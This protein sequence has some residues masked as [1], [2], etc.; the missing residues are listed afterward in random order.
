MVINSNR[1]KISIEHA[2][3]WLTKS[4]IQ[5]STGSRSGSVNAW[6]DIKKKKYSFIYSEINGYFITMMIFLYK[7]TKNKK[8]ID[9]ALMSAK[10][11]SKYALHKNGGFKCLF[12]IDKSSPH[13]FKQNQ[14]YSFDNGVILNGFAS[15]YKI[16]KKKFLLKNAI[17]CGN[18]LINHCIDKNDYVKPVYEISENKFYESDKEWSLTSSSYHT[19]IATGLINLYSITKN[20]KYIK[21]AKKICERSLQFQKKNGRFISFPFRGGTNAHPH[22][23]SAEGLWSVG[24]YLKN[25]KYLNASYSATKWILSKQNKNGQIPRLYFKEKK[26]YHE[27]VDALSQVIRLAFLNTNNSNKLRFSNKKILKLLLIVLKYQNLKNKNRKIKGSF[28]W[29]KTSYGELLYH[30]NSWVT[31]F[32]VQALMFYFNYSKNKKINFDSFDLV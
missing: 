24:K 11:L 28:F 12:L 4:G 9:L 17:K 23:Y 6:Y 8:Y 20:Q 32:S 29:G 3:E 26:I 2:V 22:C 15:L 25:K 19:K 13:A 27:R 21:F 10:W 16:T 18:W 31:F 7:Q 30:P 14:I 5:N 1:I